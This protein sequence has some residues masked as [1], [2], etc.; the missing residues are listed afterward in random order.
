M[1]KDWIK[2][3]CIQIE[4]DLTRLGSKIYLS[5]SL[6]S[7]KCCHKSLLGNSRCSKVYI[8]FY[9]TAISLIN[10]L[11]KMWLRFL[12][13]SSISFIISLFFVGSYLS[14]VYLI[15]KLSGCNSSITEA[16][17]LSPLTL[18]AST[19]IFYCAYFSPGCFVWIKT[20]EVLTLFYYY[21]LFTKEIHY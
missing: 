7:Q 2:L 11:C 4:A 16:F 18:I 15:N 9:K 14:Q 1:M 10:H 8:V 6:G 13:Y 17:D 12:I 3:L 20:L 21:C 5:L 19:I